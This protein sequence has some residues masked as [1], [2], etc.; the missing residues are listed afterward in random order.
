M[1]FRFADLLSRKPLFLCIRHWSNNSNC[2]SAWSSKWQYLN[3]W[4]S[5]L[6]DLD[7]IVFT[8]SPSPYFFPETHPIY[9][10]YLHWSPCNCEPRLSAETAINYDY[11]PRDPFSVPSQ[12]LKNTPG[13]TTALQRTEES[14]MIQVYLFLT[15]RYWIQLPK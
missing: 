13:E 1:D 14:G 2:T 8:N 15:W 7:K 3:G 4:V 5:L 11:F 6:L 9:I 10:Q 12:D